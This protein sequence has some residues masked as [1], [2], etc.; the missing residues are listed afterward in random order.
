MSR[1]KSDRTSYKQLKQKISKSF[2]IAVHSRSIL[3]HLSKIYRETVLFKRQFGS[4]KRLQTISFRDPIVKGKLILLTPTLDKHLKT[5]LLSPKLLAHVV[6]F[7]IAKSRMGFIVF[8]FYCYHINFY[9]C[10]LRGSNKQK[11]EMTSPK[12]VYCLL[13]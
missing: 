2:N 1:G 11:L 6:I 3:D 10:I 5:F 13:E 9:F 4:T 7:N 8:L 12:D